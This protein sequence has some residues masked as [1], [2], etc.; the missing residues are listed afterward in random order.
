M[1]N[2]SFC[3]RKQHAQILFCICT[4]NSE[5]ANGSGILY[6]TVSH[7]SYAPPFQ[8]PH[9]LTKMLKSNILYDHLRIDILSDWWHRKNI[10]MWIIL[11]RQKQFWRKF[12]CMLYFLFAFR[13]YPWWSLWQKNTKNNR[14]IEVKSLFSV[15]EVSNTVTFWINARF[16]VILTSVTIIKQVFLRKLFCYESLVYIEVSKH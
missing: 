10:K 13:N 11:Q 16:D 14:L 9:F 5:H 15:V 8:G 6:T 7:F 2:S 3:T 4:V 1:R 12:P